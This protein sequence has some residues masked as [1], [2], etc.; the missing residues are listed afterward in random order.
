MNWEQCCYNNSCADLKA[1]QNQKECVP[2]KC[3]CV[4]GGFRSS[5]AECAVK[6]KFEEGNLY[7]KEYIQDIYIYI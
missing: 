3:M 6:S 5:V 1:Y 4:H 7:S 2:E